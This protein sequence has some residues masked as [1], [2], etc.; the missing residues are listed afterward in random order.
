MGV[1]RAPLTAE[2][3]QIGEE[4]SCGRCAQFSL[5]GYSFD[6]YIPVNVIIGW[7]YS[8]HNLVELVSVALEVKL[9]F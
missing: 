4:S 3:L 5:N 7:D 2:T 8:Y 9:Q 6:Y 1:F